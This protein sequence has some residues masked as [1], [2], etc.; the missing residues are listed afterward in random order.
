MGQKQTKTDTEDWSLTPGQATAVDMLV[1]GRTVTDVAEAVGVTR[2]T[3]SGWL[4]HHLGFQAELSV[5]R[6][7][8]WETA[9]DQLRGLVPKSVEV[10][11]EALEGDE[12]LMVALGILRGAGLSNI[13]PPKHVDIEEL[14]V[15]REEQITSRAMR[16][17]SAM[18]KTTP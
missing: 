8:L 18:L 1:L 9:A 3:V 7:E 6:R 4:H 16:S 12:K 15:Q 11:K 13:S 17:W 2:Q 10:L 14:K 5:R